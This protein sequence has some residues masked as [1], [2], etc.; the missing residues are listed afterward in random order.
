MMF[1][2]PTPL[3][4]NLVNSRIVCPLYKTSSFIRKFHWK[5]IILSETSLVNIGIWPKQTCSDT[6]EAIISAGK[7][8]IER[9][10]KVI[11]WPTYQKSPL[12]P[13]SYNFLRGYSPPEFFL[14]KTSK[15]I[16]RTKT[17]FEQKLFLVNFMEDKSCNFCPTTTEITPIMSKLILH[18][19]VN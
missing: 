10:L 8:F 14:P 9:N 1:G 11:R 12:P 5:P 19:I 7:G 18:T 16:E 15:T 4:N 6:K 2:P 17:S 13:V 3:R